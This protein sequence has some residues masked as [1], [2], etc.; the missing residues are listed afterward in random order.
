MTGTGRTKETPVL[1][2]A[3]GLPWGGGGGVAGAEVAC[4]ALGGDPG[5]VP[6]AS[7]FFSCKIRRRD[8]APSLGLHV[9]SG[10]GALTVGEGK[11]V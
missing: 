5:R 1:P 11:L 9:G 2:Q 10:G 7:G 6:P 3:W 4:V 8:T